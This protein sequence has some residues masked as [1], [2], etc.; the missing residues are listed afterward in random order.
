MPDDGSE[1]SSNK[2]NQPEE[3]QQV[4]NK[5]PETVTQT[6]DSVAP[7][8]ALVKVQNQVEDSKDYESSDLVRNMIRRTSQLTPELAEQE[9]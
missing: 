9:R 4:E 1:E 2:V 5:I 8:H 3:R 7:E 6:E